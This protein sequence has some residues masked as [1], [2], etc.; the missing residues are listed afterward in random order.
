MGELE[1]PL[2]PIRLDENEKEQ[3]AIR[4]KI[5]GGRTG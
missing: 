5:V 4:I 2:L 1:D 3:A